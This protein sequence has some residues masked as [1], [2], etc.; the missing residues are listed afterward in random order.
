[1]V[2]EGLR[3]LAS[4]FGPPHSPHQVMERPNG[5][6]PQCQGFPGF[7]RSFPHRGDVNVMSGKE[8]LRLRSRF[9]FHVIEWESLAAGQP[10][11]VSEQRSGPVIHVEIDRPVGEDD[12]GLILVQQDFCELPISLYRCPVISDAVP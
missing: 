1:M 3:Q 8:I 6:V 7:V 9:R 12:I 2:V 4:V 10:G 5:V 11:A